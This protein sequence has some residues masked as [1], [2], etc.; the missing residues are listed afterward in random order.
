MSTYESPN[1]GL[2]APNDDELARNGAAAMRT[3]AADV[4]AVLDEQISSILSTSRKVVQGSTVG[5]PNQYGWLAV[6]FPVGSFTGAPVVTVSNGDASSYFG[7]VELLQPA[8]S[9]GF[10]AVVFSVT[11]LAARFVRAYSEWAVNH[12]EAD[13]GSVEYDVRLKRGASGAPQ[14]QQHPSGAVRVNWIAVG[15]P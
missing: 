5:T 13:A 2:R 4:D 11:T 10:V 3:L 9:T 1:Y 7:H 15:T 6:T 8:T 12:A 14:P